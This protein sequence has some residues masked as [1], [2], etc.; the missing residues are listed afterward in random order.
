[1]MTDERLLELIDAYGADPMSWPEAEREAALARLKAYPAR[2]EGALE[3]ARQL[4]HAFAADTMPDAPSGLAERILADAPA[5]SPA[6]GAGLG[7]RLKTIL[8]P[9]GLRWPAGATLAALMM[10]LMAG[11]ATAPATADDGFQTDEE[12]VVYSALGYDGLE[13]YMQEVDG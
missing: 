11:V 2:F 3:A 4:D 7:A 9:N 12:A 1:M 8:F 6:R 10:G 5:Q 13:A